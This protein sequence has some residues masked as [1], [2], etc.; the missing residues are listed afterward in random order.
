[1]YKE[2]LEKRVAMLEEDYVK[3]KEKVASKTLFSDKKPKRLQDY[4]NT[5]Y[6]RIVREEIKKAAKDG[7]KFIQLPMPKTIAEI[8][9]YIR[10]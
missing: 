7:K 9:G 6:E 10:K 2:Q 8:E 1:M 4:S 3:I 5:R